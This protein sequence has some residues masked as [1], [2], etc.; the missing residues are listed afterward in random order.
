MTHS[1]A[2][3]PSKHFGYSLNSFCGHQ[4]DAMVDSN[5]NNNNYNSRESLSSSSSS[6]EDGECVH[7]KIGS[8][9]NSSSYDRF[10]FDKQHKNNEMINL[11][12]MNKYSNLGLSLNR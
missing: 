8:N 7:F 11:I 4:T 9:V 6:N 2:A 3:S 12:D 5:N 1:P 10:E